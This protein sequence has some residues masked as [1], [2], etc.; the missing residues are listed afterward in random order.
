MGSLQSVDAAAKF[1]GGNQGTRPLDNVEIS[2]Y[3]LDIKRGM[4]IPYASVISATE[5]NDA[6]KASLYCVEFNKLTGNDANG[7]VE[8]VQFQSKPSIFLCKYTPYG[9]E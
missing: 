3:Y 7:R 1:A 9:R 4:G 2:N 8:A 5:T 6:A